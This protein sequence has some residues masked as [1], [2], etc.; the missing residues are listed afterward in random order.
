MRVERRNTLIKTRRDWIDRQKPLYSGHIRSMLNRDHNKHRA[1]R[2]LRR[3]IRWVAAL[4]LSYFGIEIVIALGIGSVSLF[5]DSVDF[6]E[7]TLVNVLI[8]TALGWTAQRRA[9]VGMSLAA[10]LLVP[11]V[12]TLWMAWQKFNVPVAPAPFAL[13][14]TGAGAL[15][16]NLT[17]AVLLSRHRRSGGSLTRAAFLSAR[18]DA[19]ANLGI[20]AAGI[21]TAFLW[22]SGWPDLFVG[23]AIAMMNA[24]AAHEVWQAAREEHA[25]VP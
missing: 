2:R 15:A 18:N 9:F 14:I 19:F 5:A 22:H 13:S 17:C 16:I 7:D 25:A 4:N 1:S 8:L 10:I 20:I 6:L 3:S 12:A 21:V 23:M 11:G 24:D